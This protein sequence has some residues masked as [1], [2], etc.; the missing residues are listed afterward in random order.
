M[1]INGMPI[2]S[3]FYNFKRNSIEKNMTLLKGSRIDRGENLK[4][5]VSRQETLTSTAKDSYSIRLT[6]D[7][8]NTISLIYGND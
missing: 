2:T 6:N 8:K 5:I 7:L 1:I 3:N 4:E